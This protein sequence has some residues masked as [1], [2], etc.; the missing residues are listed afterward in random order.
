MAGREVWCRVTLMAAD[1][2]VVGAWPV[3]G[4]G[5]PTLDL[6]DR[7]ARLQLV[8]SRHGGQMR[9]VEVCSALADLLELVGLADVV[10]PAVV[11]EGRTSGRSVRF[12]GR[13]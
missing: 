1:G 8:A 9:L 6:V 13:S 11:A 7:L 5:A 2:S 3:G 4:E 10:R 12:R